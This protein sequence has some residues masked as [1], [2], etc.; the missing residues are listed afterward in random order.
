MTDDFLPLENGGFLISQMGSSTGMAPGRIAEFDG[1]MHFVADHFGKMS[2]FDE[3]PTTPPLDGFNPHGISARP[4]LNLMMTSDFID[5]QQHADG[6][7]GSR[8][9]A[10]PCASGITA[11]ARLPKPSTCLHQTALL[12]RAPW[13]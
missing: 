9:C 6:F 8:S 11:S 10:V 12:R 13:T 2:L 4:D 7:D 3:W 1:R 5:A